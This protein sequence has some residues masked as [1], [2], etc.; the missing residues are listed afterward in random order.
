M[1][2]IDKRG[3]K[4]DTCFGDLSLGDVFQG[5]DDNIYLKT[6]CES[7]L[8]YRDYLDDGVWEEVD[9]D[10]AELIIPLKATLTIERGE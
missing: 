7:A 5:I 6:T 1:T 10:Y 3:K 9:Y 2:V 4:L 8:L